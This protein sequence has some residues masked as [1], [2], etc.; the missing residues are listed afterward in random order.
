MIKIDKNIPAPSGA[1]YSKYPWHEMVGG[2][3][4]LVPNAARLFTI[5]SQCTTKTQRSQ[6]YEYRARLVEGGVRVWCVDKD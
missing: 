6:A 5:R 2:D 1:G 4:F 3:S